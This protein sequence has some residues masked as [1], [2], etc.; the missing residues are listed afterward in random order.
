MNPHD[1]AHILA[2]ALRES[3]EF[4][5]LK[6]IQKK[7]KSEETARNMLLDFRRQ[8]L[9]LQKQHLTG[10]EVSSEQEEKLEKL[11]EVI[12]MNTD[13]KN[14]LEAEYRTAVLMRDIQKIIGEATE[15]IIDTEL[16]PLD[17]ELEKEE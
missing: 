6:E 15:S 11:F 1:A 4:K 10:V 14:F 16:T 5:T 3:E 9:E 17:E 2:K 7:L 13:V 8:Q 12:N